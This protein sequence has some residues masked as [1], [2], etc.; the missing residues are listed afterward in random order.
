MEFL[1]RIFFIKKI[2]GELRREKK[3]KTQVFLN[4]QSSSIQQKH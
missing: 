1:S 2:C 4:P 3:R